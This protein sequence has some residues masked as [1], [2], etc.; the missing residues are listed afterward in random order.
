[1]TSR[2]A[3][4]RRAERYAPLLLAVLVA[5]GT[6]A[7]ATGAL[8]LRSPLPQVHTL[9]IALASGAAVLGSR[10]WPLV[11]MAAVGWLVLA[12]WPAAVVASWRAGVR[13]RGRRLAGYVLGAAL[14]LLAGAVIGAA[15]GGER[16]LSTGTPANALALFAWLVIFPLVAGL[17][18]QARRDT[19]AALRDRAERLEREQE[20]RADRARAE[21]R[22]RIAREMHDVVAHRVS[23]M[24]VHAGALEVTAAEPATI[25][26]AALI[27]STG[28]S[29]LAD[30]RDVLGVLRQPPPAADGAPLSVTSTPPPA[31]LDAIDELVGESREAGLEVHRQDE[32]TPRPVPGAVARTAYR[33]VQEGLTNARKHAPNAEVT[34]RLCH[35]P[36]GVEVSVRNGPSARRGPALP[37]AGL[38]LVGLRERVEL[39]GGRL[40]AGPGA[41]GGFVLRALIPTEV[42]S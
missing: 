14:V 33:V 1:M 31:G 3:L 20:A 40:A 24:V 7:S 29:A 18:I 21:E 34:V 9:G 16:R 12:A 13:L 22:A 6:W 39:V 28:R 27:R 35:L 8:G 36:D 10:R 38:G 5:A 32:G 15:I 37:G 25:E 2:A 42:G 17:W 4:L 26:A 19:L 11:T 23:L 41:D 30:L